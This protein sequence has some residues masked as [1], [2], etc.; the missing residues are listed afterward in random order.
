MELGH[1][2]APVV[3]VT[4]QYAE[5]VDHWSGLRPDKIKGLA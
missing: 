2:Q 1:L 3:I 4:D 5:V